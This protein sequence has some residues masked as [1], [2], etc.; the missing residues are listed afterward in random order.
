MSDS[1]LRLPKGRSPSTSTL[2]TVVWRLRR[3]VGTPK[4]STIAL[5]FVA[6]PGV[7]TTPQRS[8]SINPDSPNWR[9][10]ATPC[11][12]NYKIRCYRSKFCS[13]ARSHYDSLKV[14]QHKPRFSKLAFGGYAVLS[15]LQ[16]SLLSLQIL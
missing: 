5:N 9:L 15:E 10:A 1:Q 2:Q 14:A 16:N 7:T 11:C 13:P 8:L 3:T 4:F 12:R 6:P